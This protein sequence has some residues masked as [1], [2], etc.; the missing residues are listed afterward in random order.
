MLTAQKRAGGL[1]D[2][3]ELTPWHLPEHLVVK[4]AAT[5]RVQTRAAGSGRSP[6]LW[7]AGPSPESSWPF[8][9]FI[10][11]TFYF[12]CKRLSHIHEVSS[13]SNMSLHIL[14]K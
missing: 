8:L 13:S 6:K 14:A 4:G 10:T 12:L 3:P 1:R 7:K 11:W 2:S 9:E 5:L